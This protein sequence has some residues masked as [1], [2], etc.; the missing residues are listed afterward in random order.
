[1]TAKLFAADVGVEIGL[2]CQRVLGA[3]GLS[4]KFRHGASGHRS[5]WHA[6]RR[7]F[8]PHAKEQHREPT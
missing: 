4:E 1:M 5:D 3:Y 8:F 2:V 7:R 6:H